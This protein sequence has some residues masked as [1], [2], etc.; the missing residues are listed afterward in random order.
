MRE[1]LDENRVVAVE[2]VHRDRARDA[3]RSHPGHLFEL[4]HDL[5]VRSH[6]LLVV[7]DDR[8]GN[9]HA[10]REDLLGAHESR[11][12]LAHRLEGADHESRADEQHDRER[13][14]GDD[15]PVA[16]AV[17][18]ASGAREAP[19]FF[20]RRGEVRR[21]EL[22]HREQPEEQSSQERDREREEQ[23]ERIDADLSRAGQPVWRV[24]DKH[25][26][27]GIRQAE[28]DDA[29]GERQRQ[30]LRQ[31]LPR[32]STRAGA[33]RRVDGQFLL[34]ASARTRNRFATFAHAMSRTSPTVPS[35]THNTRPMSPIA[36]TENGLTLGPIFTSSN[37]FRVK[38]TG[39]G[40]RSGI[41]AMRR[42]TS[43]F[44]CSNVRPGFRRATP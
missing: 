35:S 28:P 20:E 12:D 29:A 22:H 17:P 18:L 26:D 25:T 43:A 2:S 14:L 42:A 1:V 44:A 19:A 4:A 23:D 9:R 31:E 41:T 37:I 30:A 27:A 34:P 13:D 33:Q 8:F 15:Q 21:R 39:I 5:L 7:S 40:K 10:Q 32:D 11:V 3:D 24:R 36:S 6:G 38:P 16:R